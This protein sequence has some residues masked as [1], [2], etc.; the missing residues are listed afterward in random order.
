MQDFVNGE[1]FRPFIEKPIG[2]ENS[3]NFFKLAASQSPS[4]NC[5]AAAGGKIATRRLISRIIL[6]S[7]VNAGSSSCSRNF[8]SNL[9]KLCVW[10]RKTIKIEFV[11]VQNPIIPIFYPQFSPF[12]R[13]QNNAFQ[14]D[15]PKTVVSTPVVD[16]LTANGQGHELRM[17]D[18]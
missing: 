5:R 1:A 6:A 11:A 4:K 2:L 12:S 7:V 16:P 9:M 14:W 13:L 8:D 17:F 3:G 10:R 15:G 18:T